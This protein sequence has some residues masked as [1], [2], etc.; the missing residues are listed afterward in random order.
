MNQ[1]C[2]KCNAKYPVLGCLSMNC[3]CHTPK[4]E[5]ECEG[6]KLVGTTKY[7]S[8]QDSTWEESFDKEFSSLYGV[9]V[10]VL[11]SEPV[12]MGN[13]PVADIKSFISQIISKEREKGK[14]D[15]AVWKL[16]E[17]EIARQEV[18]AEVK[19]MCEGLEKPQDTEFRVGWHFALKR[20]KE[21]LSSLQEK[22]SNE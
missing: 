5:K 21:E 7:H 2:E 8:P 9:N 14:Q 12:I 18:I 13:P 11:N 3:P 17:N 22:K 10:S 19:E 20:L 15:W 6:C 4:Q 1:C 16:A